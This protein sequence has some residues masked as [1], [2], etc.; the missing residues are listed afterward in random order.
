MAIPLQSSLAL[1]VIH[2]QFKLIKAHIV[3]V[4]SFGDLYHVALQQ[5]V[6]SCISLCLDIHM[7]QRQF[8]GAIINILKAFLHCVEMPG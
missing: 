8:N 1:S 6:R 3:F 7:K 5:S 4:F 2:V